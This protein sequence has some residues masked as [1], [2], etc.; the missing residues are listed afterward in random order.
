MMPDW[1]SNL[2]IIGLSYDVVGVILLAFG[3]FWKS[4]EDIT[5]EAGTFW[6]SNPY[7]LRAIA[8]SQIDT[9]AGLILL[10]LGFFLQM[11]GA[12]R[13]DPPEISIWGL[14]ILIF[15]IIMAYALGLRNFVLEK[16]I[17]QIDEVLK[18]RK[19]EDDKRKGR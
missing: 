8:K 17:Q 15:I 3:I 7:M 18:K 9:V 2:T 12:L 16:R 5:E 19:E 13:I 1:I 6:G 14:W 11:L 4:A 10:V